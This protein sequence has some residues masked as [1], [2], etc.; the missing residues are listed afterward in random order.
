MCLVAK[1]VETNPLNRM[2]N[3]QCQTKTEIINNRYR[4]RNYFL[5]ASKISAKVINIFL[6]LFHLEKVAKNS[7]NCT[8]AIQN[9]FPIYEFQIP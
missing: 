3:K 5:H 8:F 1:H 9:T 2:K 6:A 4:V 7:F